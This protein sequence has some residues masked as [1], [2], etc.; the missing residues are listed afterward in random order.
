MNQEIIALVKVDSYGNY[1]ALLVKSNIFY[2]F[3]SKNLIAIR[4]SDFKIENKKIVKYNYEILN[5]F[6]NFNITVDE[7]LKK[8]FNEKV[9]L[10]KV[11]YKIVTDQHSNGI[12]FS[13]N[14]KIIIVGHAA[15]GKDYM[16]KILM[17]KGY[18]YDVSYTTRPPREKEIN[19]IDYHFISDEE[20]NEKIKNEEFL[21]WDIFPNGFKYGTAI[22]EFNLKKVF[23]MTP[24]V[25]NKISIKS[26]K[27]CFVIYININEEERRKRLDLRGDYL[28]TEERIRTDKEIIFSKDFDFDLE[29]NDKNFRII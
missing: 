19:G 4:F 7:L 21:Q 23:I 5:N 28:G 26:L 11:L 13:K 24:I 27:E 22:S 16:K 9:N 2:G 3:R 10:S 1:S 17:E 20:F 6:F 29:I 8:I 25:L 12:L 14:S 18:K 15:S